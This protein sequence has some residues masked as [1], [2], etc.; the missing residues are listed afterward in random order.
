MTTTI[1]LI[2]VAVL[3]FSLYC[4]GKRNAS[5]S[6][7]IYPI[8]FAMP[9]IFYVLIGDYCNSKCETLLKYIPGASTNCFKIL[10]WVNE[11]RLEL[12]G[13]FLCVLATSV[14]INLHKVFTRLSKIAK[15]LYQF[16]CKLYLQLINTKNGSK[17]CEDKA[18]DMIYACQAIFVNLS[19]FCILLSVSGIYIIAV[20]VLIY[21]NSEI[22]LIGYICY[23]LT[24]FFVIF[25]IF[26]KKCP[27]LWLSLKRYFNEI[28]KLLSH[29]P[30]LMVLSI[31]SL[32]IYICISDIAGQGGQTVGNSGDNSSLEESLALVGAIIAGC[33]SFYT[34][35]RTSK[36][37]STKN[38]Q[39][40]ITT[41]R[42]ESAKLIATVDKIK[43]YTQKNTE[44]GMCCYCGQ[45]S[46]HNDQLTELYTQIIEN[47]A[48]LRMLL[49]PNDLFSPLLTVQLDAIVNE[50]SN[51][52]LRIDN[53]S[54][55]S[56][57]P[58]CDLNK[59]DL[60]K[61]FMPW[62][63]ILLKVEWE[64]IKATLES[65]EITAADY[66]SSTIFKEEWT[67]KKYK[68]FGIDEDTLQQVCSA[69]KETRE[70]NAFQGF[71][72][73]DKEIEAIQD[74]LLMLQQK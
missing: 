15:D 43:F 8:I 46:C 59:I 19:I 30:A 39:A 25:I 22:S 37:E 6:P 23:T 47:A 52:I 63:Q 16:I 7:K 56:Y 74:C 65:R 48:K 41:V 64:R 50:L 35:Q 68:Q 2:V 72:F 58:H 49:N 26:F 21:I 9:I 24:N 53:N 3:I 13:I 55:I 33:F 38:R 61:S 1:R 57:R 28:C 11:Y 54:Y 40:W 44:C 42:Y 4:W 29:L 73:T 14:I 12:T 60:R 36:Q 45:Y 17:S 67:T 5:N 32:I 62:I 51:N 71:Y 18:S 31:F 27:K 20:M 10:P 70:V 69:K 66:Y 34:V